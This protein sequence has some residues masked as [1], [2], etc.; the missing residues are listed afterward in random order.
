M[1]YA[2]FSGHPATWFRLNPD[3]RYS[4]TS[5]SRGG[6]R[7]NSAAG[8]SRSLLTAEAFAEPAPAPGGWWRYPVACGQRTVLHPVLR[9]SDY[10]SATPG[11]PHGRC[12]RRTMSTAADDLAP[13][14]QTL[15]DLL[16]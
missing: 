15:A 11:S 7:S 6:R 8:R 16:V 13:L 4:T 5:R 1:R 3:L 14:E 2:Q 9:R 12:G 10:A